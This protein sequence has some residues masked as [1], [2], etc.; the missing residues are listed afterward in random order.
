MYLQNDGAIVEVQE[1]P[2]IVGFKADLGVPM[3]ASSCHT[4]LVDGYV[5]EGHVPVGAVVRLLETK[6]GAV[7]IALAGMPADSPGM[8]GD[9]ETWNAQ[10]VVLIN[11]DGT[12]EAFDY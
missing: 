2:N 9:E 10:P 7:G 11:H 6:P 8:G 12:L 5:V 1:D 4:A 3:D